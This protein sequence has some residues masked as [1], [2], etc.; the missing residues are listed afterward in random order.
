MLV[1][2][3]KIIGKTGVKNAQVFCCIRE[4]K[5]LDWRDRKLK[6]ILNDQKYSFDVDRYRGRWEIVLEWAVNKTSG[7]CFY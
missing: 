6:L 3:L 7:V 1:F 2:G 5:V 4:Y